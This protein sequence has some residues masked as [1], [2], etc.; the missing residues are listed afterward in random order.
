MNAQ[1]VFNKVAEHLLTQKAPAIDPDSDC[2]VYRA[3]D[4]KMCA[5]G[6]LIS[7]EEYKPEFEQDGIGRIINKGFL[8]NLKE[9]ESLLLELQRVHDSSNGSFWK[10]DL[11]EVS[12]LFN[13]DMSVCNKFNYQ[14][15]SNETNKKS[16]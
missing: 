4:G 11:I 16:T 14:E 1:E 9:H 10:D 7:D 15:N 3:P 8:P 6:C 13:L 12:K 2:C 5:V